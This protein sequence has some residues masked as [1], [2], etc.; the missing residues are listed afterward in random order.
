MKIKIQKLLIN[1]NSSISLALEKLQ[2]TGYKCL[3]VVNDKNKYLGTITD[4]DIRREILKNNNFSKSISKIYNT[5]SHY[6]TTNNFDEEKARNFLIKEKQSLLPIINKMRKVVDYYD[7]FRQELLTEN[8]IN[9]NLVMIMAGGQGKRLQPFTSILPKALIPI[10]G[11]PV[12]MHIIE[13]F[14]KNRFRNFVLSLNKKNTVLKSYLSEIKKNYNITFLEEDHP[15][16]TA[17]ALKNLKKIKEPFF[18][19][20]CDNIFKLNPKNLLDYHKKNKNILT[21]VASLKEFSLPYGICELKKN[22]KDLFDLKEK[23]K[24]NFLVNTGF[25]V[26]SPDLLKFLPKK[27]SFGMNVL[28]NNLKLKKK[29][30]N[31]SFSY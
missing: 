3:I 17:G 20:N 30:K 6:L 24:K 15:L 14:K 19:I 27:K 8:T 13:L 31:W 4:G 11:K 12:L 26:C 1:F 10:N 16:G 28:I 9:K 23:P 25:Y 29:K 5:N 18:L 21:L 2:S 7:F 22:K